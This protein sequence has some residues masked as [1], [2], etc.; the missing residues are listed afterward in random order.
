MANEPIGRDQVLHCARL[1]CI[2][3]DAD[4]ADRLIENLQT[5]VTYVD[6]LKNVE[7]LPDAQ[8]A[9]TVSD[10][11]PLLDE[12]RPDVP[13]EGLEPS[14]VLEQAACS[15]PEGFVLPPRKGSGT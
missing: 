11:E 12:L 3:L 14:V 6:R 15:E 9:Q 13:T 2:Q 4:E 5:I 10:R 1:A 7:T 8:D